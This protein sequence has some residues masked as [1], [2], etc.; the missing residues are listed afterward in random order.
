MQNLI[1]DQI[2]VKNRAWVREQKGKISKATNF[3]TL[4]AV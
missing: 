4:D 1:E 3:M 2:Y